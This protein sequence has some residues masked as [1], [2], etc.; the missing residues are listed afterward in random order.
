VSPVKSLTSS[1]VL[2][3]ADELAQQQF[4]DGKSPQHI[5]ERYGDNLDSL[6]KNMQSACSASSSQPDNVAL[7]HSAMFA[8]GVYR[9]AHYATAGRGALTALGIN[10]S[11]LGM[12][13]LMMATKLLKLS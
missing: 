1:A 5:R 9:D 7:R 11:F 12:H 10:R 8:V 4:I 6:R 2:S 13:S 3:A